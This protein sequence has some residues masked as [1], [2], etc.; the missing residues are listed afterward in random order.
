MFGRTCVSVSKAFH[1]KQIDSCIQHPTNY[2]FA[3]AIIDSERPCPSFTTP[4]LLCAQRWIQVLTRNGFGFG[5]G[6]RAFVCP[7][8]V[9]GYGA[10]TLASVGAIIGNL[11]KVQ[12][13]AFTLFS[14]FREKD[15]DPVF[16]QVFFALD[17][18]RARTHGRRDD[19]DAWYLRQFFGGRTDGWGT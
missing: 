16:R 11:R 17:N 2:F 4:R 12:A 18:K 7:V 8:F 6:N 15:L 13:I 5:G 9:A 14:F 3:E 19:G 1:K 10:L